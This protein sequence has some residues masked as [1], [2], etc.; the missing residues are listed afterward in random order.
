[1]ADQIPMAELVQ[2]TKQ[3]YGLT[4]QEMAEQLGR[5]SRMIRKIATGESSG[6]HYRTSL[7]ELYERGQVETMTP[8]RRTKA[9]K[10]ARVRSKKGA[11]QKST[12]PIDTRGKR[13]PSVKRGRFSFNTTH[14]PEGNRIHQIEMPRTPTSIGR[15]KGLQAF[16]NTMLRI[17]KSQA[18]TDKR[19]KVA[20]TVEDENGQ[21]RRYEVGTKSGFHA[22]DIRT[23][24][25]SDHNGN[26]EGWLRTQLNAVYPDTG[27][28]AV[29]G[30]DLNEHNATRTK[31]VRKQEDQANTRRRRW[32]R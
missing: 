12:I 2:K 32:S 22:S 25:R 23:D 6:E 5:S 19:V 31:E 15:K 7:T 21:R 17:T 4:W 27:N 14:L 3:T 11:K 18:H 29:V 8:R 10:L 28:Y 30:V 13:A 20:I 24:I 16:D 9:G 1:M 26:V